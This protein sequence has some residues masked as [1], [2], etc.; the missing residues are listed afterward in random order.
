MVCE[1]HL[2]DLLQVPLSS[3]IE[4]NRIEYKTEKKLMSSFDNTA[5]QKKIEIHNL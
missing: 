4:G 5:L 3:N 2:S 1:I